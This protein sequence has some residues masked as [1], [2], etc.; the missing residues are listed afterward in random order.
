MRYLVLLV[1]IIVLAAI[2]RA[3]SA[4]VLP[5]TNGTAGTVMMSLLGVVFVGLL[6]YCGVWEHNEKN[7]RHRPEQPSEEVHYDYDKYR[8]RPR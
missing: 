7:G 1:T 3:L 8:Q 4:A 5:H 2:G 6:I